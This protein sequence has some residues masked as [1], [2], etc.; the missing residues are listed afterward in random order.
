AAIDADLVVAALAQHVAVFDV[1]AVTPAADDGGEPAERNLQPSERLSREIGGYLL[2]AKRTDAWDAIVDLL[3]ALDAEHPGS[4]HRLMAGCR[5]L[6]NDGFE[7]DGL[8][9]LLSDRD[10]DL[11]DLAAGREGRREQ[12]GY[13]T[14]AQ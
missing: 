7:L 8:D 3:L 10:Q 11:F 6:S 5:K 9:D 12:K 4:F 2:E 14:P 1:A 13:V